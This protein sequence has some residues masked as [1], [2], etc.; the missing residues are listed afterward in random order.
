L[1]LPASTTI[2]K[3]DNSNFNFQNFVTQDKTTLVQQ[4]F[5]SSKA[6][7]KVGVVDTRINF[8]N[9]ATLSLNVDSSYNGTL[10]HVFYQNDD[11]T[12]WHPH[13]TCTITAGLC[14]F[15]TTHATTYTVNGDGNMIGETGTNVNA[16]V[17]EN[18]SLD[19]NST[20]PL[21]TLTPGT[22]VEAQITCTTT[23]NAN[24]G[25]DLSVKRDDSTATLEHATDSSTH[26][27]DKTDWNATTPN[28]QVWSGTGLGFRIKELGTTASL[29]NNT[30]WG[31]DDTISEALFAGFPTNYINIAASSS[32]SATDTNVVI[33]AKL[34]VPTAQRSAVYSGTVTF[35][36]VSKP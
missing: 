6:A 32:Y 29:Y 36:V 20:L 25:Y 1:T 34:D 7:V 10:M 4:S 26:I 30:W 23:T 19:C 31:D 35:Q 11:E 12:D 8:S 13:T 22:P 9:V 14:S 33:G 3:S 2:T 21:G 17:A 5:I 18:I 28:S 24:G 16:T 27:T 15:T